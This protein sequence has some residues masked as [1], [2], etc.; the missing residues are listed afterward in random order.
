ML[1]PGGEGD[2]GHG[3]AGA[4]GCMA[5]HCDRP[6]CSGRATFNLV[7]PAER[8]GW[9]SLAGR[10]A[11]QFPDLGL[12]ATDREGNPLWRKGLA[13]VVTGVCSVTCR[14][15]DRCLGFRP[16]AVGPKVMAGRPEQDLSH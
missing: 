10:E 13:E 5:A 3:K 15:S 2:R 6:A 11:P 8:V 9:L 14:A 16:F 4:E 7:Y 12:C 1:R